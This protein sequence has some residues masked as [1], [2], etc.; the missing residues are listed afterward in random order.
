MILQ[1]K[2]IRFSYPGEIIFDDFDFEIREG[3]KVVVKGESGSGKT[4]FFRLLLGFEIPDEGEI[5][6]KGNALG[7]D[8][9]KE[10]RTK[11][12]WL[13][14]DLN[15]GEGVVKEVVKYPFQ[16]KKS[17]NSMPEEKEIKGIFTELGLEPETLD[18]TFS[19]LST[20]QRQRVGLALCI[21]L[22]KP[23]MLL[24]EPT[25]AL[26]ESSKEKAVNHLFSDSKRTIISTSHD[27]FWINKCSRIIDLDQKT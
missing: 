15:L 27:P 11:S 17:G 13:P 23:V 9:L 16:F 26:D 22:N 25:S 24:D 6:F 4:T 7:G 14:Q 1:G 3:E 8:V 20:G 12:A 2:N 10:L 21:L 19:D 5:L 18:K